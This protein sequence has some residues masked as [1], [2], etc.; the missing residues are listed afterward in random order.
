V[1]ETPAIGPDGTIY[2][3]IRDGVLHAIGPQDRLAALL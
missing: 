3:A 2:V 1:F